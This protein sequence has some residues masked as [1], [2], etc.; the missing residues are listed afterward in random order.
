MAA[1]ADQSNGYHRIPTELQEVAHWLCW[2][3]AVTDDGKPTKIPVRAANGTN[4]SVI[5]PLDW[6]SFSEAVARVG[7]PGFD[8][9]G[10]V[11]TANDPYCGIDLDWTDYP[12]L[13]ARQEAISQKLVS[14]SERSQSGTGLHII[15]KAQ[16][17]GKG[18]KRDKIEVY[19]D[20]RFFIF[21]G[22]VHND[23]LIA[24][25]QAEAVDIWESLG[26]TTSS[27]INNS[28]PPTSPHPTLSDDAV[29]ENACVASSDGK[30]MRLWHGDWLTDFG[31]NSNA[32]DKSQSA[33]D[34]ALVN[35]ISAKSR[36]RDQIKRMFRDSELG[37]RKKAE[38]DDYVDEMV[39]KSFDNVRQAT[40]S[41][42][43]KSSSSSQAEISLW[44]GE[45]VAPKP[46]SWLWRWYIA[47]GKLHL[48]AGMAGTGKSTI[49]F[50]LAAI[51]S[52]GSKLPDGTAVPPCV[53]LIWSSEDD[54][55]DTIAPR[56]IAMHANMKMIK[57]IKSA[58]GRPWNPATDI[59]ALDRA[60]AKVSNIG[61]I[62]VDPITSAVLGDS[63][64]AAEV[65]NGLQPLVDLGMRHGIAI[66]GITHFSKGTS[67]R[68]PLERVIGSQAFGAFARIV[69]IA[70][71][72]EKDAKDGTRMFVR[73]KSNIG[74]DGDGFSYDMSFPTLKHPID[75][76][77]DIVTA[78]IDWKRDLQGSAR[79]LLNDA[80]RVE[81]EDDSPS[82]KSKAVVVLQELL[83]D[84]DQPSREIDTEMRRRD[85]SNYAVRQAKK[86]LGVQSAK[87]GLGEWWH[88]LPPHS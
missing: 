22:D 66:F 28:Q 25:Y 60:C 8:G 75:S 50:S 62:I 45:Y 88:R 58:D 48:L 36:D 42:A 29:Y 40:Q 15:V 63:H 6:C 82:T 39:D 61:L 57:F 21:T 33:A 65:R 79:E 10:F 32:R 44:D 52:S 68:E 56:L 55:E 53:V 77:L 43:V 23:A 81:T 4:A 47:R 69:Y 35:I 18:R 51:L 49:A 17:P 1:N 76:N 34:Q 67:G 72:R 84:G 83:K 19:D 27:V 16:L 70:A 26:K 37:K 5:N 20:K 41:N 11:F 24:D 3:H 73:I 74:P 14:Y 78:I 9:I 80:E 71:K 31:P 13:L 38:R 30:F 7:Q 59:A 2:K 85:I 86:K 54:I 64:K 12:A 87:S 46:I